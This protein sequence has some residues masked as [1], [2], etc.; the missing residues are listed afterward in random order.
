M[1][2][3]SFGR[4]GEINFALAFSVM[5]LQFGRDLLAQFLFVNALVC[6]FELAPSDNFR[7]MMIRRSTIAHEK[8]RHTRSHVRLLNHG[9]FAAATV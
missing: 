6:D 4:H 9:H 5:D 1:L 3:A 7:Y 8:P 2:A